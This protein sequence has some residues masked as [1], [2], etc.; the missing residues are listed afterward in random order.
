MNSPPEGSFGYVK[1]QFTQPP[2]TASA[3]V[4]LKCVGVV[5][6]AVHLDADYMKVLG[7]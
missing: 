4:V 5:S 2:G 7:P 6:A 1:G 3:K